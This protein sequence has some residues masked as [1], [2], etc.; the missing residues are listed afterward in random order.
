MLLINVK[1][2]LDGVNVEAY[3]VVVRKNECIFDFSL[4]AREQISKD[5]EQDFERYYKGFK[6][7]GGVKE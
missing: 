1:G 7:L 4:V 3:F 2:A 6:Y 5:D